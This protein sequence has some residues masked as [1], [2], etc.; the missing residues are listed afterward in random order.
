[1]AYRKKIIKVGPSVGLTTL[2][3][4]IRN[5]ANNYYFDSDGVFKESDFVNKYHTLIENTSGAPGTYEKSFD[6]YMW[7]DGQYI[8]I[9]YK[10]TGVSPNPSIDTITDSGTMFIKNDTEVF[11]EPLINDLFEE[12]FGK[13]I[14]DPINKTLTLYKIDGITVLKIFDLTEAVLNTV[15]PYSARIPR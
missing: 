11:N 9:V 3:C 7:N 10:M 8:V 1:M 14:I 6:E 4:I 13:W 12:A 15:K 5:E 2:Y